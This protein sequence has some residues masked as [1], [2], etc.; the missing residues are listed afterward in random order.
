MDLFKEIIEAEKTLKSVV[1]KTPLMKNLNL[2]EEFNATVY[3]KRED[4]Q[5]C[6]RRCKGIL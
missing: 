3:L 4:L 1:V 5:V 2:S 6:C